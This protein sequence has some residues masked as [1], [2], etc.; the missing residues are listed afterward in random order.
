M[1]AVECIINILDK[2]AGSCCEV[3]LMNL[4]AGAGDLFIYLTLA[5]TQT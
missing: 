4:V 3:V 5:V 1:A 2:Q